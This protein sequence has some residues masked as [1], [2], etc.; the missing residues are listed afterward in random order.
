MV[1]LRGILQSS[2]APSLDST[3]T[4]RMA[5]ALQC[6]CDPPVLCG[7]ITGQHIYIENGRS[8]AGTALIFRQDGVSATWNIEVLQIE[9]NS[10]MRAPDGCLQYYVGTGGTFKSLG[11]GDNLPMLQSGEYS[12]C[13]R[14]EENMCEIDYS[15]TTAGSFNLGTVV[16][17]AMNKAISSATGPPTFAMAQALLTIPGAAQLG[18]G[19]ARLSNNHGETSDATIRASTLPFLVRNSGTVQTGGAA[20][21]DNTGFDLT[22][23]QVPC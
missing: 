17:N 8:T 10:M 15:V 20:R 4:L 9:C 18:Y 1:Q 12:I 2:A 23:N 21:M 3:F 5:E 16:A 6:F 22:W 11:R 14:R 13:F 19:G 7:T